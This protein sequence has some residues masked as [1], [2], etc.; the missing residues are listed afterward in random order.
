MRQ[1]CR[2]RLSRRG[3]ITSIELPT[4]WESGATKDHMRHSCFILVSRFALAATLFGIVSG[5]AN[6]RSP[7]QP[8]REDAYRANN[9]GVAL[10][11]QFKY[12]EAAE[13]FRRALKVEPSLTL[14]RVN[15]GI[16]LFNEPDLNGALR[17]LTAAAKLLPSSPQVHYMLGL[18]ARAQNRVPDAFAAL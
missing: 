6:Q 10:L 5:S 18:I 16:A 9:I 14:A 8:S 7:S 1:S 12:N 15:L 13:E 2:S 11:E 3:S 17:E 4:H